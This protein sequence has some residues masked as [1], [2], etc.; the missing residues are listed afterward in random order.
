[1]SKKTNPD[2]LNG[3]PELLI[4]RML[5]ER[6]MHGYLLVQ[7]LKRA[8][9]EELQFGE[10]CIYPILH[11]L[12]A[13]GFLKGRQMHVTGRERIT[14]RLTTKGKK[15]LRSTMSNWERIARAVSLALHGE[16]YGQAAVA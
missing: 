11:R 14:Y 6:E 8:T 1:M 15:R 13:D 9:G 12:E 3:V 4:L 5:A 7:E 16:S 2:F 10:G